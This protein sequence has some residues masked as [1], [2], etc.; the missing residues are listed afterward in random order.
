MESNY[1]R[2]DSFKRETGIAHIFSM[3]TTLV[4]PV[5]MQKMSVIFATTS[6]LE[7]FFLRTQT[8]TQTGYISVSLILVQK[9]WNR[10]PY[11]PFNC[12]SHQT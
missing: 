7:V 12:V 3:S 4:K 11:F 2:F 6:S 1:F 5:R 8:G 10:K 9:L